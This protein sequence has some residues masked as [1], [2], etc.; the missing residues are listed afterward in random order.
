[1]LGECLFNSK[2]HI[3]EFN[4]KQIKLTLN[5][6]KI[7]FHLYKNVNNAV[8][9]RDLAKLINVSD[10]TIDVNIKRLREKIYKIPRHQN[11]LLTSRGVRLQNGIRFMKLK[12]FLPKTI[13]GRSLVI[14]I[15][16]ILILQTLVTYFFY[17]RH[18]EDVGRRLVLALGGQLDFIV[19]ELEKKP[20][21]RTYSI[22][23]G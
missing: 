4:G 8:K 23:S 10:R 9:R 12:D 6:S 17:E 3:L 21:L 1:M 20:E 22:F 14:I 15:L 2:E 19:S 16:P 18:W 13:F 5:E 11:L 7:L